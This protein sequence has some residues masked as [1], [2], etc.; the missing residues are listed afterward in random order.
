MIDT[1]KPTPH[2]YDPTTGRYDSNEQV[3]L[4]ISTALEL[5]L[6]RNGKPDWNS[7]IESQ[8]LSPARTQLIA[9]IVANTA[10]DRPARTGLCRAAGAGPRARPDAGRADR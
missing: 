4:P 10:D 1:W 6:G 9:R 8:S 3:F 2:F 7:V 5:K